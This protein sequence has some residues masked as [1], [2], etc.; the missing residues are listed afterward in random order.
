M[1][2]YEHSINIYNTC[3]SEKKLVLIENAEHGVSYMFDPN[4]YVNELN[5]FIKN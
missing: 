4:T 3:T 2:P 5:S 1:V